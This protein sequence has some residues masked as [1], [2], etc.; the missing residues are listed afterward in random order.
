MKK[1]NEK[2]MLVKL[3]ISQW[4][5]RKYDRKI[6]DKVARDMG[7]DPDAGRYTKVLIANEAIE[8]INKLANEIRNKYHYTNTLPWLDDGSRILPA[9]NFQEYSQKIRE[10]KSQ[11]EN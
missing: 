5:A 9:K 6:S 8:K 7:A 10:Y 2:A 11:F 3:K 4:T 1:L